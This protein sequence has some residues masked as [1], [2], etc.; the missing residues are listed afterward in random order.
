MAVIDADTHVDET[1]ATW[2][3]IQPGEEQYKPYGAEPANPDPNRRPTRYWMIDGRR[4]MRIT[5]DDAKT[6]TTTAMREL[7]DVPARLRKMDELGVDVHVIYPTTF[8]VE[9]TDKPEVELAIRRSYN[10]WLAA[11]TKETGGRLRW[12]CLPPMRSMDKALEELRF[13]KDHGACGVLKKGNQEADR[14]PSDEYFYPLYEEAEKLDMPICCHTGSGVPDWTPAREFT[15][16]AFLRMEMSVPNAFESFI[17]F[18]V[19]KRFPKLRFGFIEAG[20]SWVPHVIYYMKRRLEKLGEGTFGR[21]N[22]YELGNSVLK[23][24]RMYVTC[25]VDE[26]LPYIMQY[27]GEDNLL[28]GSDFSHADSAQELHFQDH[29]RRRVEA[30]EISETAVRKITQSNPKAFYGL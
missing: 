26:D 10:R 3:Y 18:G 20:A 12:V 19:T 11:R 14:W 28:T 27:T 8:L 30:G 17:R 4:Q 5:R 22:D 1:E 6:Q 25:Q 2:E 23:Q 16:S 7:L 9:G 13:A 21:P 29:L 15:L 24:H